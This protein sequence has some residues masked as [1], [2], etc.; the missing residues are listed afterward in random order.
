ML[1]SHYNGLFAHSLFPLLFPGYQRIPATSTPGLIRPRLPRTPIASSIEQAT[2]YSAPSNFMA[3]RKTHLRF[4]AFAAGK[5][6]FEKQQ[7]WRTGGV[8]VEEFQVGAAG[9]YSQCF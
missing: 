3:E 5:F 1:S 7:A 9:K 6:Q 4:T 8:A 2:S